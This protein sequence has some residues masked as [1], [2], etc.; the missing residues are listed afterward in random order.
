MRP[1][2]YRNAGG[3]REETLERREE[4]QTRLGER[5]VHQA[6]LGVEERVSFIRKWQVPSWFPRQA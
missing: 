2:W 4:D 3:R 6:R 5:R 1:R